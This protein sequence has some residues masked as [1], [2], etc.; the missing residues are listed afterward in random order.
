M[1]GFYHHQPSLSFAFAFA[2]VYSYDNLVVGRTH[3]RSGTLD[4]AMTDVLDLVRVA[5]VALIGNSDH[6]TLSGIISIA[7]EL[8]NL[9]VSRE[10]FLK[11]QVNWN[12]VCDAV[13]NNIKS[14][15]IQ[16]VMQCRSTLV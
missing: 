13:Q 8:P 12:T 11:H 2:T 5:V 6:S 9:L 3:A 7:Q 4:L 14:T 15:G 1:V 16:S 10:V